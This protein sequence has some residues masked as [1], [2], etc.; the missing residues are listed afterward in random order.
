MEKSKRITCI[1]KAIKDDILKGKFV[2]DNHT[3][4]FPPIDNIDSKGNK[5]T[6]VISV[7][8]FDTEKNK[9][10]P[11]DKIYITCPIL[12]QPPNNIIA[13]IITHI[14]RHTGRIQTGEE[15]IV[16]TG[17]NI[18]KL[19]ATTPISQA[20]SEAYRKYTNKLRCANIL[21]KSSDVRPF[22]MLLKKAG[23]TKSTQLSENDFK[24][25]VAIQP[26]LDGIRA[27]AH[28]LGDQ[29][30]EFY[31]RKGYLFTGLD[32]IASEVCQILISQK[33][34]KSTCI[35]LDGE[36]HTGENDTH[37]QDISG[38]IRGEDAS[39]K[40]KLKYF[41]FDCFII[42]HEDLSQNERLKLICNMGRKKYKYVKIVPSVIVYNQ[43]KMDEIYKKFIKEGYEGAVSRRLCG[44]YK[45][46]IGS[47][48]SSD[49]TKIKPFSTDEYEVVDYKEGRGKDQGAVSFIL[50]TSSG[51]EF[52]AVP[53]LPLDRRKE[54]F[55]SFKEHPRLFNNK[56]KKKMATIQFSDLSKSGVP[57]QPKWVALRDYESS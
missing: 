54:I 23:V 12:K 52:A 39:Q 51:E 49:V 56:Y 13:K 27:V 42:G 2:S 38:A 41:V 31:S 48:R 36:I 9:S 3:Y 46:G 37:L 25:G 47:Q 57:M 21:N 53:N 28:L 19:N 29:T 33:D 32:H 40:Q 16:T 20:I 18:D 50:K 4:E 5:S 35:Y 7:T 43:K 30:V 15:T 6:W 11:I 10:I 17:K 1:T 24:E 34:Y 44:L 8:A 55:S 14:K 26:K 22:P 45:F